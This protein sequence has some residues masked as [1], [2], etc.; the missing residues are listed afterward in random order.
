MFSTYLSHFCLHDHSVG[1]VRKGPLSLS[2]KNRNWGTGHSQLLPKCCFTP[3]ICPSS[4]SS[5]KVPKGKL[6]GTGNSEAL[7]SKY[8]HQWKLLI[9]YYGQG[10]LWKKQNNM[11]YGPLWESSW[12]WSYG[13][14]AYLT[15]IPSLTSYIRTVP[16]KTKKSISIALWFTNTH[17]FSLVICE[18]LV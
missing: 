10:T 6:W 1:W 15:W 2:Y 8:I 9:T 18:T 16:C 3:F 7:N 13:H 5:V 11:R 14:R 4:L 12:Q 17:Y